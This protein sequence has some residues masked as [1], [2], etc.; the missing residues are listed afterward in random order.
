MKLA[1]GTYQ[2][3][4][5]KDLHGA[6]RAW[7]AITGPEKGEPAVIVGERGCNTVWIYGSSYFAIKNLVL[8][9]QGLPVDAINPSLL[10][11][12]RMPIAPFNLSTG[13]RRQAG[14]PVGARLCE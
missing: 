2:W 9:M 4:T 12:T 5:L 1:P 11:A 6:P 7:I 13:C 14:L 8:D 3:L 10:M